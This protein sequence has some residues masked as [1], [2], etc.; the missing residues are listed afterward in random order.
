MVTSTEND[1]SLCELL[2]ML[3]NAHE[4]SNTNL[5][6]YEILCQVSVNFVQIKIR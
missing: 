1:F 4:I 5:E 3:E 6:L 2:K